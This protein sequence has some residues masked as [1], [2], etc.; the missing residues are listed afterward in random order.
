MELLFVLE[1]VPSPKPCTCT[2][3]MHIYIYIYT[4]MHLHTQIYAY[5]RYIRIYIH[6]YA[7]EPGESPVLKD[8][9]DPLINYSYVGCVWLSQVRIYVPEKVV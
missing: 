6:T 8:W 4:C 3:Y 9:V 2:Y 7:V 1:V 5:I